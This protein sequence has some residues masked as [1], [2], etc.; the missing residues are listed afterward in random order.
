MRL[1]RVIA[2]SHHERWDGSGYPEGLAGEAIP[3]AAR[4]VAVADVFDAL[5]S[6]RPYKK[7]WT[8]EDACAYI[9][10]ERGKHLDPQMVDLFGEVLPDLLNIMEM[11]RDTPEPYRTIE[12][13]GPPPC[14]RPGCWRRRRCAPTTP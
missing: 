4:M 2:Q 5:T 10:R 12:L 11:Y 13:V 3:L 8:I 14:W 1:S 7:A 9:Q 6:E